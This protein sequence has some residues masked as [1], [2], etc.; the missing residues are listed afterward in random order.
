MLEHVKSF[1][2]LSDADLKEEVILKR[3]GV[4]FYLVLNRK[5]NVFNKAFVRNINRKLDTVT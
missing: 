4:V 1:L 5:G 3:K 2:E